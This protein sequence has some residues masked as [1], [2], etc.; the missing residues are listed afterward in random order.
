MYTGVSLYSSCGSYFFQLSKHPSP[1]AAGLGLTSSAF[2]GIL[3][4]VVNG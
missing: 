2:S 3:T 4:K 1:C